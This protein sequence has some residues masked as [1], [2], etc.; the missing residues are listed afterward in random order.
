M[1]SDNNN[2]MPV[3]GSPRLEGSIKYTY[4]DR[5][6]NVNYTKNKSSIPI[7]TLMLFNLHNIALA[8]IKITG[9]LEL[10]DFTKCLE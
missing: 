4:T 1:H 7:V 5:K 2:G 6:T 3:S 8:L 9:H 10:K